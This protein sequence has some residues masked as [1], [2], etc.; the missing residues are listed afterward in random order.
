MYGKLKEV[1]YFLIRRL[2]KTEKKEV[3]PATH[4]LVPSPESKRNTV[5]LTK[6]LLWSLWCSMSF[7]SKAQKPLFLLKPFLQP[8]DRLF[9]CSLIWHLF[10]LGEDSSRRRRI[11]FKTIFRKERNIENPSKQTQQGGGGRE[12]WNQWRQGGGEKKSDL[13]KEEMAHPLGWMSWAL[14]PMNSR[15]RLVGGGRS[16]G[17]FLKPERDSFHSFCS[18]VL[19]IFFFSLA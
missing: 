11:F 15:R 2:I 7:Y 6:L 14:E 3:Q 16:F 8:D 18:P 4:S 19:L 10:K 17:K 12:G 9:N 1:K 5:V 13:P